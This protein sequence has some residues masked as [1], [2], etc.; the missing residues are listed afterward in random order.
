VSP[1]RQPEQ[2]APP[3]QKLALR[4]AKRGRAR[5]ASHRD[6]GRAFERALRRAEVPMA[7]SSGFHPHPRISYLNASPTGAATQAE[8]MVVGLAKEVDPAWLRDQLNA[9][10][11]DGL[12]IMAVVD[13]PSGLAEQLKAAHWQ[14][15][16]DGA[17]PS[18]LALAVQELLAQST[19]LVS[20]QT[21]AG[22]REFDVRPAIHSLVASADGFELMSAIG[23][24][25][26]RPEDV[27]SA[28]QQLRPRLA[29][30][31]PG[32]ANRVEQGTWDGERVRAPF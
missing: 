12:E 16:L 19:H 3:V 9:A 28:L 17:D 7:F 6:F 1:R 31:G 32:L 26:V 27:V 30:A 21:K 20:R 23:E 10:L 18:E 29:D 11:P 8:Y 25:L 5:F 24:P 22:M 2:Q 4:Y 14:V 13:A 15:R